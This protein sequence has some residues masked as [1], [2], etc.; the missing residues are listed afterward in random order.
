MSLYIDQINFLKLHQTK[1]IVLG[2][3][4]NKTKIIYISKWY[5]L[6]IQKD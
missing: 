2:Q 3:S 1:N 6:Y 4:E 5:E